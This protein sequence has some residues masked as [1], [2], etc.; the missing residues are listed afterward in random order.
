[1]LPHLHHTVCLLLPLSRLPQLD[2]S[3]PSTMSLASSCDYHIPSFSRIAHVF[4]AL[5]GPHASIDQQLCLN[6]LHL[7]VCLVPID[8]KYLLNSTE[9]K[10]PYW[11]KRISYAL[12]CY[13]V[14]HVKK[15]NQ[16]ETGQC[17]YSY[18]LFYCGSTYC[19]LQVLIFFFIEDLWQL[20]IEQVYWCPFSNRFVHFVSLSHILV[21]LTI[22]QNHYFYFCYADVWSVIFDITIAKKIM[23]HW[24]LRWWLTYFSNILFLF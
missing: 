8:N 11:F 21:I 1:M 24:R 19:H 17:I 16:G 7:D 22:F 2:R 18:I 12:E 23:T 9:T 13:R 20:C 14:C 3:S 4:Y 5:L 10:L 6:S 15:E